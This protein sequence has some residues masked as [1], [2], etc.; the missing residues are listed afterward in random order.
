[1]WFLSTLIMMASIDFSIGNIQEGATG[2]RLRATRNF[3]IKFE[4]KEISLVRG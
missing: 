4:E 2:R 1:M 3:L